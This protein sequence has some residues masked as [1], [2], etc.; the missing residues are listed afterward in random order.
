M[1][2]GR[3][4]LV[5]ESISGAA[6]SIA[7]RA[8]ALNHEIGNDAVKRKS[9]VIVFLLFFPGHFVGEFLSAFRQS[10][11]IGHGLGR[12]FFEQANHDISLRS[13]EY[14]IRS[15]GSSHA[16]SSATIVHEPPQSTPESQSS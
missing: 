14:G 8:A 16:F 4:E 1:L 2:Q 3:M 5:R 10:D 13:L 7:A 12:F 15:S 11:E 9:I 6:A